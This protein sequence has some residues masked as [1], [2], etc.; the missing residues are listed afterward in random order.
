MA[1]PTRPTESIY[2]RNSAWNA[3]Q[4]SILDPDIF[5]IQQPDF[6]P[7]EPLPSIPP[8]TNAM[9]LTPY[10][11]VRM[12]P[13]AAAVDLSAT[14]PKDEMLPLDP[15]E[16]RAL[17]L[18]PV[19]KAGT[20]KKVL[21]RGV[22]DKEAFDGAVA[23]AQSAIAAEAAERARAGTVYNGPGADMRITT[24]GTGSAIPSKYRNVSATML[25]CPDL[26]PLS[27][28]GRGLAGMVLLDCGEGTL[29][30]MR[31]MYGVQGMKRVYEELKMVFV[32]HMHADHHLGLQLI[33]E[34]RFRVS[35]SVCMCVLVEPAR[36]PIEA[37][38]DADSPA[39]SHS[40]T[41]HP[42]AASNRPGAARE[43]LMAVPTHCLGRSP[44]QRDVTQLGTVPLVSRYT[45]VLD[46]GRLRCQHERTL[47]KCI[48]SCDHTS[49][50]AQ[51]TCIRGRRHHSQYL[52]IN[53]RQSAPTPQG[54]TTAR[55]TGRM[56][57]GG[58]YEGH[59]A[60]ARA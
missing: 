48:N 46:R 27:T 30:Q 52:R 59:E 29:G 11:E 12:Y 3:T 14:V 17:S 49:N 25:E 1:D 55:C 10:T 32:S 35:L 58:H 37:G 40:T 28:D 56:G 60:V 36:S 54:L 9:C 23:K 18:T 41:L 47:V 22:A 16:A 39:R 8:S 2:F 43:R 50:T 20:D 6:A 24:L 31:R 19:E 4:L 33:L 13:R 45:R 5:H 7:S 21:A 38:K 34:D 42:C 51:S 53:T 44:Q 15:A 57:P 26:L